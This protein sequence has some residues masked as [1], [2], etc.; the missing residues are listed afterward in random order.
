M[1]KIFNTNSNTIISGTSGNDTIKNGGEN[2]S[3]YWFE[4]GSKITIK[5][6][7]GNDYIDNTQN[8]DNSSINAGSG[9]DT[10][11]GGASFVTISGGKGNDR[12]DLHSGGN[13]IRYSSGDGNDT[14]RGF[15]ESDTLTIT[16]GS[17]ST[18]TSG[19]NVIVTVGKGK[20]TLL[21]ANGKS[22][23]INKKSSSKFIT[24]NEDEYIF[25]NKINGA[26]LNGGSGNNIIDNWK[27]N[28]VSISGGE[29]N[30]RIWNNNGNEKVTI[31]CGAGND[32]VWNNGDKTSV[33]GGNGS[34]TIRNFATNVTISGGAGSDNIFNDSD[35]SATISGGK[36]NDEISFGIYS[37]NNVVKYAS[38]DGND[39]V[40]GFKATDTLKISGGTYSTQ[41]SGYDVL[42]KVGN[43]T[44]NLKNAYANADNIHINNKTI[45][46]KRKT[47]KLTAD[48]NEL[49]IVRDS[50]SVVGTASNDFIGNGG[51]NV[52][53]NAGKGNDTI[54][55]WSGSNVSI[56]G[57]AGADILRGGSGQ[58]T[59]WGGAGNDTLRGGDGKD[60]FVYK[61][62]EGTDRI[63]DYA[64]GDMLKILKSNGKSGGT[65]TKSKFS[66]GTLSLTISG[67]GQILL[68]DVNTSTNFNINGTNYKISGSTL[69]KS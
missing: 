60:I 22:L 61:P 42:V 16:G 12:I 20:I 50:V 29:G 52:T 41:A 2:F 57:G 18:Q 3:G 30:D 31:N 13:L 46:L 1:A 27:G 68:D 54:T 25:L 47:I 10:I 55:N 48:N 40:W 45:K 59:L 62:N 65:F 44:I 5:A 51:S 67:G 35:N 49:D 53:I 19:N 15:N 11:D 69:K 21:D 23:N 66:D 64:S 17:Y 7:K 58:S 32:S 33:I 36:G 39:T 9:N 24:L 8:G 56:Y 34:D 37:K 28:N 4:G 14:I 6:G 26:T 43:G 63:F 38:G